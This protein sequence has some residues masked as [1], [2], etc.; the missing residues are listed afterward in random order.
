MSKAPPPILGSMRPDGSRL[1]VHPA[2]VKGRW[3]T[4][5]HLAFA[6]L[7]AFYV[8]APLLPVGGH[9][10][11]QLDVAHRRFY[12]F[13]QTFNAQDFW[14]VVLL[15]L[16]FVFGL[17][18]VTA[19]RGRVWCGWA[20]PQTVFLEGV[21]RPIERLFDGP[22][23]RRIRD[24]SAPWSAR[25]VARRAAK[26]GVY[27][28]VSLAIAHTATAIFVGP[29]ELFAMVR[30]G[31]AAHQI[32]FGLTMGFTAILMLN[33]T[34]FREQFCVV[35]CPYGRLQSVLHDRDS[36]TVAYDDG[37]GEPRGKL[38]KGEGEAER[39]DCIDCQRCVVVCP[40]AIDIRNGLQMECL[41][42]MQ[43][44]DA[45]DAVMDKVGRRR[46]LIG[47][48][49]QQRIAGEP[50]RVLR[51]RL[52]VYAALFLV[53]V[54]A[55]GASLATRSTFEA[56]VLRPRGANPFVVDGEMVRNAFEIHLVNKGPAAA[57]YRIGVAAPVPA[58]VVVGTPEVEVPSL[59][60]VRVPISVSIARAELSTPVELAVTIEEE[61]SDRRRVQAV[62]FLAPFAPP[63]R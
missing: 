6:A 43:C 29:R 26:L 59:S 24:M 53:S 13:G 18:F 3:M 12:L 30:E 37:R 19:W 51:P 21:Y 61:G 17:L 48:Y 49:S 32:A 57:R 36:V 5:R 54:T 52:L 10:A 11:I 7:I 50:T 8:L 39:G 38:Y 2:D 56:N 1:M 62:R 23:D 42:C 20:C 34:W 44:V 60:D 33:F 46:G 16:S 58:H 63:A 22:R 9:P 14:M 25:K 27:L 55:L 45:C 41:A 40:T 47:L 28:I 35:L 4:R 31:P 15:A